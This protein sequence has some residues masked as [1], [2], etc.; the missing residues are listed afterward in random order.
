MDT[1]EILV[2]FKNG[3]NIIIHTDDEKNPI[4]TLQEDWKTIK[5]ECAVNIGE[6]IFDINEIL[7]IKVRG[8]EIE[9]RSG[10]ET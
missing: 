8:G 1:Y 5:D 3:K 9:K 4:K 10:K 2:M 7:Y 6:Y